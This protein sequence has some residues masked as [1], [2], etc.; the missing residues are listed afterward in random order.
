MPSYLSFGSDLDIDQ[1]RVAIGAWRSSVAAP[2]LSGAV[3]IYEYQSST[4]QRTALIEHSLV[5][6][7]TGFGRYV[8]LLGD[9]LAV[10]TSVSPY[11]PVFDLLLYQRSPAGWILSATIQPP[12]LPAVPFS[13][14][15]TGFGIGL[16]VTPSELWVGAPY[17]DWVPEP[18]S[19]RYPWFEEH[20]GAVHRYDLAPQTT[21][22]C[23][24]GQPSSIGLFP[25]LRSTGCATLYQ[26]DLRL[27]AF[28][29]PTSTFG[30]FVMASTCWVDERRTMCPSTTAKALGTTGWPSTGQVALPTSTKVGSMRRVRVSWDAVTALFAAVA[31][32]TRKRIPCS[33]TSGASLGSCFP[34]TGQTADSTARSV[35]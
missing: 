23:P 16:A 26:N 34:V 13:T 35:G 21:S 32:N 19:R 4:W 27:E 2:D 15:A 6:A 12:I 30:F 31:S 8:D 5:N 14:T 25:G 11:G 22:F 24:A 18:I 28:D 3:H 33:V 9:R 17:Q 10:A 7:N 1:G 29:L 20:V